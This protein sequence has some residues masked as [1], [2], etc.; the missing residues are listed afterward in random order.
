MV[1]GADVS[2][3]WR[4]WKLLDN[5]SYNCSLTEMTCSFFQSKFGLLWIFPLVVWFEGCKQAQCW[6]SYGQSPALGSAVPQ[7]IRP[8]AVYQNVIQLVFWPWRMHPCP[9]TMFWLWESHSCWTKFTF[10]THSHQS[11][12]FVICYIVEA[13][14]TNNFRVCEVAVTSNS[15]TEFS[16]D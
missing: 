8:L 1:I 16:H 6:Q 10:F 13:V 14:A 7:G 4:A 5:S 9:L 11:F 2:L 12:I 15:S 3:R